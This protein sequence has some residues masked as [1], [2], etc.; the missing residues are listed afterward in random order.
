MFGLTCGGLPLT[1]KSIE[2]IALAFLALL[3]IN[4]YNSIIIEQV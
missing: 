4:Y 3:V 2:S 1:P